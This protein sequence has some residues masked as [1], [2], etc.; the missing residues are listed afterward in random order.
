[1]D[2]SVDVR[3]ALD[4]CLRDIRAANPGA[5]TAAVLVGSVVRG[6]QSERSDI[7]LVLVSS[8]RLNSVGSCNPRLH[9]QTFTV[10]DFSR[11]L[12]AGD[13]FAAWAVRLGVLLDDQ[14]GDWHRLK[15]SDD[16]A[17]WP[18]WRQKTTHAARRL[19]LAADL[20]DMD[21]LTAASEETLYAAA[22]VARAVLLQ[23]GVFPLSRPELVGQLSDLGSWALA[24][25]LRRLLD[26]DEDPHFTYRAIRYL[27]RLLISFDKERYGLF[28]ASHRVMCKQ[29][30]IA[31]QA[32]AGARQ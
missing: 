15:T 2:L 25:L 5:H 14:A 1:V 29:R 8:G 10:E 26:Y 22:H 18:D 11:K 16:A 19:I 3:S 31:R 4:G 20:F 23:A 24:D 21:D 9:I 28:A 27:K 17:V 13:D 30:R 6:T 7:D 32:A 12:R